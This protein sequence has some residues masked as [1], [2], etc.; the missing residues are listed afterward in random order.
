MKIVLRSERV[1]VCVCGCAWMKE[2][3]EEEINKRKREEEKKMTETNAKRTTIGLSG[4]V[5]GCSR[6]CVTYCGMRHIII[7]I[8]LSL[9]SSFSTCV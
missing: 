2:N 8:L 1:C 4:I 5:G 9:L 6:M 7:N 3:E